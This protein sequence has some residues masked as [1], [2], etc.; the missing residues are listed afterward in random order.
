MTDFLSALS[1]LGEPHTSCRQC[2]RSFLFTSVEKSVSGI[3]FTNPAALEYRRC[4]VRLLSVFGA[5]RFGK[6]RKAGSITDSLT[7][8]SK[9][10][11]AVNRPTSCSAGGH[12]SS[13]KS[14]DPSRPGMS[15]TNPVLGTLSKACCARLISFFS[16]CE[17]VLFGK[18]RKAGPALAYKKGG[19]FV[20]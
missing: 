19:N 16:Q 18:G 20:A 2:Q 10:S 9:L 13:F 6:G 4:S 8:D 7:D 17:F 5:S 14:S 3:S 11:S 1:S 15:F 12:S